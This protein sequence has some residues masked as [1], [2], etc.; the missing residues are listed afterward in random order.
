MANE[1]ASPQEFQPGTVIKRQLQGK[2]RVINL[3]KDLT[4]EVLQSREREFTALSWDLVCIGSGG[5]PD[6]AVEKLGHMLERVW[7]YLEPKTDDELNPAARGIR[8]AYV[9]FVQEEGN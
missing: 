1:T 8:N 3:K 9:S 4:I 6:A 2:N 7:S 5:T